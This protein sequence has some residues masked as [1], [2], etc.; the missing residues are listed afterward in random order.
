M[1]QSG[2]ARSRCAP[3]LFPCG[4]HGAGEGGDPGPLCSAGYHGCILTLCQQLLY[5]TVPRP[6]QE[7]SCRIYRNF[8]PGQPIARLAGAP[9]E[10]AAVGGESANGIQARMRSRR[11]GRTRKTRRTS[12]A[13]APCEDA[14]RQ[15][16]FLLGM[17]NSRQ[18]ISLRDG[19]L[20]AQ[21]RGPRRAY[22]GDPDASSFF[23]LY[24]SP[25]L[26][27]ASRIG[28]KLRPRSVRVYSTRGGT[29]G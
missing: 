4:G 18:E 5:S 10:P 19:L 24:S 28:F 6:C 12:R 26:C 20:E 16:S 11:S 27:I 21:G 17:G 13:H 1:S 25:Q 29:S 7:F 15:K 2:G 3:A 9:G 14:D 8:N 23:A 22:R